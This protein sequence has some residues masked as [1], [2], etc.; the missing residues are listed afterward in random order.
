MTVTCINFACRKLVGKRTNGNHVTAGYCD[1]HKCH[2][3]VAKP[4][5]VITCPWDATTMVN[6]RIDC[7][8]FLEHHCNIKLLLDEAV[9]KQGVPVVQEVPIEKVKKSRWQPQ[10]WHR[11]RS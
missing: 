10:S 2:A 3:L 9:N 8:L 6:V 7:K 5:D 4:Q 1:K 11:K